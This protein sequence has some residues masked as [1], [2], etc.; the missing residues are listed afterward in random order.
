M[1]GDL[2]GKRLLVIGGVTNMCDFVIRAKNMGVFVIVADYLENSPAKR[3]ANKRVEI[4]A[5]DVEGLVDLCK[6]ERVDGVTTGYVDI[7]LPVCY[8]VCR[9]LNLPYYATENMIKASTDKKFFKEMCIKYGI[10][11]PDSFEVGKDEYK[12]VAKRLQYPVFVKPFDSSGSRGAN[13]CN[14][15]EEFN[16][17]YANALRLSTKKDVIVE[18]Y[19]TGTEFILDYLI[20]DGE[21]HLLSMQDRLKSSERKAALNHADLIIGPSRYLNRYIKTMNENVIN[22]IKQM[23]FN[24]GIIFMQGY[25][26]DNKISFFE[27]G[28]RLGGSYPAVVEYFENIHPMDILIHHALT[29]KMVP[30]KFAYNI[31]PFY[32]GNG[33]IMNIVLNRKKGTISRIIAK[34]EIKSMPQVLHIIEHLK[35]GESFELGKGTDV[36]ALT[37]FA[38]AKNSEEMLYTINEIYS[39]LD[40]LDNDNSSLL[41]KP[42]STEDFI[43]IYK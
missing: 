28:C 19:L 6:K 18:E 25:A 1:F 11:V 24:N 26:N 14:N 33:I 9:K 36:L 7:L 15:E 27:M 22:M 43:E 2:E 38:V 29:G 5:L 12:E 40:I 42:V 20:I 21:V 17:S 35:E 31:N 34:D 30:E 16:T 10:P 13:V 4:D 32:S 41:V 8:E 37:I 39:R 3:F 23:G